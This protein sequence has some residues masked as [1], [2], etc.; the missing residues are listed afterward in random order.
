MGDGRQKNVPKAFD[1]RS[2]R[3]TMAAGEPTQMV[4]TRLA[5]GHANHAPRQTAEAIVN[6]RILPG[7]SAE[8]VRQKLVELLADPKITSAV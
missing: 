7:H 2:A 3:K 8:A 4:A 1:R 5:A 6:C